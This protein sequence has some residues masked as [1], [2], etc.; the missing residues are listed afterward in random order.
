MLVVV[1]CSSGGAEG[2]GGTRGLAVLDPRTGRE[3]WH[4]PSPDGKDMFSTVG[5]GSG[6]AVGLHGRSHDPARV[7]AYDAGSGERRWVNETVGA[8]VTKTGDAPSPMVDV[9][10]SGV[11]VVQGVSPAPHVTGLDAAK[12]TERWRITEPERFVGVSDTLVF[13]G[14]IDA[15]PRNTLTAFDRRSG[16]RRWSFPMT[17]TLRTTFQVVAANRST[18]VVAL[19]PFS[20]SLGLTTFFVLDAR[21]GRERSPSFRIGDPAIQ[22]SDFAIHDGALVYAEGRY[23]IAR[24]LRTGEIRWRHATDAPL[25]NPSVV[26][27]EWMR[28]RISADGRAVFTSEAP[29]FDVLDARTGAVR[30]STSRIEDVWGADRDTAIVLRADRRIAGLDL[31]TGDELWERPIADLLH[32]GFRDE[33]GLAVRG[34]TAV[35]SLQ[36]PSN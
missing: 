28:I 23:A 3:R 20:S 27:A 14:R 15:E 16:L 35:V 7:V 1:A 4:V 17:P 24:D 10:A 36:P 12:G 5:V 19:G 26:N 30:W 18:V 29:G 13:T 2:D 34:S 22:F 31:D 32:A 25:P 8:V 33:F 6:L 9:A 11:V 21:T